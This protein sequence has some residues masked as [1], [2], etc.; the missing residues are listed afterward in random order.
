MRTGHRSLSFAFV[1]LLLGLVFHTL[2]DGSISAVGS[3][4]VAGLAVAFA[5]PAARLKM[6]PRR[7]PAIF[8]A[9]FAAQLLMHV[10]LSV[11][12]HAG[13]HT[14]HSLVPGALMTAAHGVAALVATAALY[15]ADSLAAAWARFTASVLGE[16][17]ISLPYQNILETDV[18]YEFVNPIH[19]RLLSG[20]MFSRGPPLST[21]IY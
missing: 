19:F 16:R 20:K 2:A 10:I 1:F 8:G 4:L 3:I 5:L 13:G 14:S 12:P 6:I 15:F 7:L 18:Q 21:C 11:A 17:K 9:V